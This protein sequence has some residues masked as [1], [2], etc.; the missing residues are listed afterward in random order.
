[1]SRGAVEPA[2]KPEEANL[3]VFGIKMITDW[4]TALQRDS[5]EVNSIIIKLDDKESTVMTMYDYVMTKY[6]IE[7]GRLYRTTKGRCR[8]FLPEDL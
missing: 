3:H 2:Q 6:A 7:D 4:I 5:N 8:L 1:L